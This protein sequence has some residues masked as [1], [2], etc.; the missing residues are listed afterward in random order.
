MYC[1]CFIPFF[2]THLQTTVT[3]AVVGSENVVIDGNTFVGTVGH[4]ISYGLIPDSDSMTISNN[5]MT[6][7]TCI[8]VKMDDDSSTMPMIEANT[9]NGGDWGVYS[10]DTEYV[11]VDGNTFNNIANA[12]IRA[13]G[14]DVDA[15]N[16]VINDTGVYAIYLDSL[17]K[18]SE[19][20]FN[21]I[22]GVNT[23]YAADG[24][25]FV[26]LES[27]MGMWIACVS[28]DIF[29]NNEAAVMRLQFVYMRPELGLLKTG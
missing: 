23:D 7:A 26:R 15:T 4:N 19:L 17:E 2:P 10:D 5:I 14:G 27:R 21:V 3:H 1:R 9:F 28:G 8:H 12:A 20:V 13:T 22:G 24:A 29:V 16:N 11:D 18:A 6:C 25:S